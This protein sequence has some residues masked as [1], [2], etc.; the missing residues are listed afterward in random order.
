MRGRGALVV[1]AL[2]IT[3][4]RTGGGEPLSRHGDGRAGSP[5]RPVVPA[6]RSTEGP[7]PPVTEDVEEASAA[8]GAPRPDWLGRRPLPLRPDGFGEVLPTPAE[9]DPRH[10]VT[11]DGAPPPP[12]G[13]FVAA[14]GRVP[15]DVLA[16]ST[17][18]PQCPVAR[19]DLRHVTLSFWGFDQRPHTG[20]LL[21][22]AEV[23]HDVVEVFRA[24]F[25]ARFPIE[26]MRITRADEL[27]APPTGD[28]NNTGAFVCRPVSGGSSWSQHASGRAVDVNPFHNP[29]VRGGLVVP[30]LAST[31]V[32]RS[33]VRPGMIVPGGVVERAFDAI[34]WGWGGHWSSAKDWMH[35]SATGR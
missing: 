19:D 14:V 26:E 4:C 34:G 3:A 29:Y 18:V 27:H 11:P 32:D 7:P 17:W 10:L 12:A 20:E 2:V 1:A 22:H 13:A 31:Y 24:L 23:A 5:P 30:E 33:H 28:G 35:F 9:L 21:L 15:D 6:P 25:E 8:A 16:R